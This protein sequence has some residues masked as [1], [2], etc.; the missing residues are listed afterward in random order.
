MKPK[1]IISVGQR[2]KE[3][4]KQQGLSQ[5]QLGEHAGFHYSY[6][7]AIERAEKNISL[8]NL[9]K[10][11]DSLNVN[12]IDLLYYEGMQRKSVTNKDQLFNELVDSMTPLTLK[13]LKKIQLFIN[14]FIGT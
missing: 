6:I 4:R 1:I 12:V 2:I 7:G 10:I 3:L 5:E 13:D 11:A 14:E 9:Q 8:I